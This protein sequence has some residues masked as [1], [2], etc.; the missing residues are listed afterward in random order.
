MKITFREP[1]LTKGLEKL[2]A[3][4][5]A[6]LTSAKF[7]CSNESGNQ[8]FG[9]DIYYDA[10]KE[11]DIEAALKVKPVTDAKNDERYRFMRRMSQMSR[12]KQDQ[13]DKAMKA[14]MLDPYGIPTDEEFDR[15]IDAG[16][17]AEKASS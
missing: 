5:N 10:D 6:D 12:S 17:A 2:F 15:V 11:F 1:D 13:L 7:F 14:A 9:C 3:E 8:V 16:I 4:N